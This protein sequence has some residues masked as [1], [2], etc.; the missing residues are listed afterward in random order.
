MTWQ[1]VGFWAV[2]I[3]GLG[4]FLFG[5][6]YLS[7]TLK[8]VAGSKLRNIIAKAASNRVKG[9]LIGMFFTTIIQSSSGTTAL[10]IGLVRAGVMTFPAAI[11][12]IIGANVGTT[13]TAFL[14]SIPF[15]EYMPFVLFIGAFIMMITSKRSW[16]NA[17][18]LLFSFGAIFFGLLLMETNLKTLASEQWFVDFLAGLTNAPWLGLLVGILVTMALQSSSAVIGVLQ[19]IYAA[20]II[21]AKASGAPLEI[22]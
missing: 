4:L 20:S 2:I 10:S 7:D 14:I 8:K 13:V 16:Q 5:I 22:T 18:K 6:T 21:A 3:G 17:S 12:V 1:D 11:A 9:S 19:G 15:G